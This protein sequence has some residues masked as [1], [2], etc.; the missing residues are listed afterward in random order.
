MNSG[1]F[2]IQGRTSHWRQPSS[3]AFSHLFSETF[4]RNSP[5]WNGWVRIKRRRKTLPSFEAV[6]KE[7]ISSSGERRNFSK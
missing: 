7:K 5:E 6:V 1:T 4:N 2:R 3:F